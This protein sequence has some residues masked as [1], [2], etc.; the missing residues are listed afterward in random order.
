MLGFKFISESE[1]LQ[2]QSVNR[3]NEALH[4]MSIGRVVGEWAPPQD[5]YLAGIGTE[6]E[7]SKTFHNP[8]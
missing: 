6:E 7:P 3:W 8:A 4:A 1:S 5:L 2:E